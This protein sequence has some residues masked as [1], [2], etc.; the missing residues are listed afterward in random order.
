MKVTPALAALF[1]TLSV[2]KPVV[3]GPLEN[4]IAVRDSGDYV[5]ALS[6]FQTLANQGV[7][8]AQFYLAAMY[9]ESQGVQQDSPRL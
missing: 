4:A 3:A 8:R 5:T 1:L 9:I 6:V 2:A 7:T